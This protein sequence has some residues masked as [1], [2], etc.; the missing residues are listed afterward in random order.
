MTEAQRTD[1]YIPKWLAIQAVTEWRMAGGRLVANLDAQLHATQAFPDCARDAFRKIICYARDTAGGRQRAVTAEDLRKGC[2]WLAANGRTDSSRKFSRADFNHFDRLHSLLRLPWDL[3]ATIAWL[4]PA[5]DDL[6]RALKYL[7][8]LANEGR[9]IAISKN[10][11][12]I[13]DVDALAQAQLD[14]LLNEVKRKAWPKYP[15]REKTG[16]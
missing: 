14:A 8:T 11:W 7:R 13:G 6:K 9:L 15:R 2:N 5:Q 12:G 16:G 1:F 3:N 10:A 4:N